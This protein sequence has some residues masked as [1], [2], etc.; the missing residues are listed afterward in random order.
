MASERILYWAAVVVL[1]VFVGNHFANKYNGGCLADRAMATVQ[2]LS[3]EATHF[4]AFAQDMLGGTPRF[5]GPELAMARVQSHFASMQ[6]DLA[7]QQAACARLEAQR[8]RMMALE[9]MQNVRIRAICPRQSVRVEVPQAPTV[10][11][12]GTI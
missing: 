5:A 3:G 8:A 7:R 6:A 1:A 10:S 11:H 4:V 9:Q 12:D 2:G